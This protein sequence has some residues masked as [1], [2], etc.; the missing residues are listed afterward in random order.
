M[1]KDWPY[2]GYMYETRQ[3][4][5]RLMQDCICKLGHPNSHTI[6]E[7]LTLNETVKTRITSTYLTLVCLDLRTDHTYNTFSHIESVRKHEQHIQV[8]MEYC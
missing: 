3:T 4:E 5:F 2:D 1:C 6:C 8:R 7:I